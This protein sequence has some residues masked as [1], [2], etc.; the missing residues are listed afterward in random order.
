MKKQKFADLDPQLRED[1][2]RMHASQ[3]E[4]QEVDTIYSNEE[5][6]QMQ[7]RITVLQ[8]R[9]CE[10]EDNI[11]EYV[12]P[13]HEEAKSIKAETRSLV[14]SLKIGKKTETREVFI[15][16]DSSNKTSEMYDIKGI[17]VGTRPFRP[18]H[19]STVF[20]KTEE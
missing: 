2:L 11:A 10:I 5:I 15:F 4:R 12:K 6:N 8:M 16:N 3:V 17:M 9:N 19:Q 18:A 20:D 13:L 14:N 7:G 1:A